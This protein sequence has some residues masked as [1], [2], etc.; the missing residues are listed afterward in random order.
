M[1]WIEKWYEMMNKESDIIITDIDE[2]EINN[3]KE[4]I[5]GKEYEMKFKQWY[6]TENEWLRLEMNILI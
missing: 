6:D 1:I 3:K 5:K 2:Q 4:E